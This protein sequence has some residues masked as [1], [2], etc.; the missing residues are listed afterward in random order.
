MR[1]YEHEEISI[2]TTGHCLGGSFAILNAADIVANGYNNKSDC[3]YMPKAMVTVFAFSSPQVGNSDFVKVFN[4]FSNLHLLHTR[5]YLDIVPELPPTTN[6][7]KMGTLLPITYTN[8][9][10]WDLLRPIILSVTEIL[11]RFHHLK[12]LLMAIEKQQEKKGFIFAATAPT[13]AVHGAPQLTG[14]PGANFAAAPYGAPQLT[15]LPGANFAADGTVILDDE[16]NESNVVME[17]LGNGNY[18]LYLRT[19]QLQTA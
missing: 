1:Q 16:V 12:N 17:Q 19:P 3:S 9:T 10:I 8:F 15:G 14:H 6:Y 7:S 4:K 18:K 5:H 11:T 2:T 13:V